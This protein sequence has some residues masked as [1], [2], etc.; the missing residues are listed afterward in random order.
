[1]KGIARPPGGLMKTKT[2]MLRT[3]SARI[4][5]AL[6]GVPGAR[7]VRPSAADGNPGLQ[8]SHVPRVAAWKI[9]VVEYCAITGGIDHWRGLCVD[10]P[11]LCA[12]ANAAP[13]A[14]ALYATMPNTTT[15]RPRHGPRVAE[16]NGNTNFE[17]IPVSSSQ[18]EPPHQKKKNSSC[19]LT[20]FVLDFV[21]LQPRGILHLLRP[22]LHLESCWQRQGV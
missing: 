14:R 22:L 21:A 6:P 9:C 5:G 8:C 15:S 10:A 19:L 11:P 16:T 13:D 3:R 1:M 17:L 2:I 18:D 20:G 4:P 7:P 12:L